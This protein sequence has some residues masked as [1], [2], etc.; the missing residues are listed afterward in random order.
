[1]KCQSLFFG[2]NKKN[3][4]EGFF[5]PA[6]NGLILDNSY[7]VFLFYRAVQGL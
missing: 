2:K 3:I 4:L 6:H 1:M 7:E 5:Y